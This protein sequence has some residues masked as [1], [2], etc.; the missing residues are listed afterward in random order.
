MQEQSV[1]DQRMQSKTRGI[2]TTYLEF[3][4]GRGEEITYLSFFKIISVYPYTHKRTFLALFYSLSN[5]LP[6]QEFPML[7]FVIYIFTSVKYYTCTSSFFNSSMST[8]IG[9]SDVSSGAGSP[10]GN[11]V[12]AICRLYSICKLLTRQQDQF[13]CIFEWLKLK[14]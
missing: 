11:V 9:Y 2:D 7:H 8:A 6:I 4:S 5:F 13:N 14:N 10:D 3:N 12:A 1:D